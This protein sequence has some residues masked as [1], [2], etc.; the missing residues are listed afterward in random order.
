[1][2]KVNSLSCAIDSFAGARP[3]A[4]L[5]RKVCGTVPR[6]D[7]RKSKKRGDTKK[8]VV[9]WI[10]S[11]VLLEIYPKKGE[12]PSQSTRNLTGG[13]WLG[14]FFPFKGTQSQVP[15]QLVGGYQKGNTQDGQKQ[16]RYPKRL[17]P[18]CLRGALLKINSQM[19]FHAAGQE[20]H[21]STP[22]SHSTGKVCNPCR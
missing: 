16:M 17:V 6:G 22:Q 21:V 11:K 9:L 20:H 14:P 19:A 15:F 10:I 5:S 18:T 4:R 2:P 12:I 8:E 1:M 13:S 7:M 3:K